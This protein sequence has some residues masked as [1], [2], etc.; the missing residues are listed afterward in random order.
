MTEIEKKLMERAERIEET[1]DGKKIILSVNSITGEEFA[2][3]M[4]VCVDRLQNEKKL[5]IENL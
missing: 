1:P 4:K 3:L 2:E 5:K